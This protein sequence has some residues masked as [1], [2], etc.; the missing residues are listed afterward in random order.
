MQGL[1]ARTP[2]IAHPG[3]NLEQI[4][5]EFAPRFHYL[6]RRFLRNHAD[7]ED[8]TQ[9][10]FLQ[11]SR[12]LSTF[13]GDGALA[14]WL[15]R[16]AVNAALAYRRKRGV[17][18]EYQIPNPAEDFRQDGA[19]LMPIRLWM[20]GPEQAVLAR[21][22]RRLIE[23]AIGKLPR[24]YRDVYVLAD[25]EELSNAEIGSALGL[26]LAAV[27]S[28]LLRARLLMR[29]ALSPHFEGTAGL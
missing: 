4:C 22:T 6:A 1:S 12:K 19:H 21:E 11:V 5:H 8:A 2:S 23:E 10:A 24:T 3:L 7:A 14:S 18:K 29:N 25:V 13:R 9:D 15:C 26:S 27:K 17:R 16:V 20:R 28:R